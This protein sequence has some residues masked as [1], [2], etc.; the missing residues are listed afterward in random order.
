MKS[1]KTRLG[2]TGLVVCG[3]AVLVWGAA[4]LY[5]WAT[6]GQ[7]VLAAY[8][9]AESVLRLVENTVS[10]TH[11][12]RPMV[13]MEIKSSTLAP[14]LS[15]FLAMYTTSRRLWG[16]RGSRAPGTPW[17]MFSSTWASSVHEHIIAHV[18][19]NFQKNRS[20]TFDSL[21]FHFL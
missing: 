19:P 13:P 1:A 14:G 16:I 10:Y 5:A 7:E 11:L 18:I 21:C 2:F 9:E 17:R 3:A 8:G 15:N 4:D 20:S 12:M 6:T